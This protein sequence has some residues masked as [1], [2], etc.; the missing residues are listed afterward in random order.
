MA[1]EL[2]QPPNDLAAHCEGW[3]RFAFHELG[4][5]SQHTDFTTSG[6][7]KIYSVRFL[8]TLTMI[9]D[10]LLADEPF[11]LVAVSHPQ[12]TEVSSRVD[13][14]IVG[15]GDGATVIAGSTG[16]L[17]CGP[18]KTFTLKCCQVIPEQLVRFASQSN[19]KVCES[20]LIFYFF[21]DQGLDVRSLIFVGN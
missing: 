21:Q 1:S 16:R 20:R 13:Q 4:T 17:V 19:P 7:G 5:V 14:S 10:H 11:Q 8:I 9:Q 18:G 15:T 2:I 3:Q 12:T 6:E